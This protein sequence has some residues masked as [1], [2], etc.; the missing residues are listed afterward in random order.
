MDINRIIAKLQ[1]YAERAA[2]LSPANLTAFAK[3]SKPITRKPTPVIIADM[4]WCAVRH[5]LGFR[6]YAMW[7]FASLN[8]RERKTWMTHPRS[9]LINEQY[10]DPQDRL[11]FS[12]KLAFYG[13][14]DE[15]LG[16]SWIN[17]KTATDDDFASFVQAHPTVVVKPIDGH[18]GAGVEKRDITSTGSPSALRNEL[19]AANQCLIEECIVQ[20]PAIAQ[21]HPDSVNTVRIIGF[22]RGAGDFRILAAV[23]RIGNGAAV[24][25]FASGGMYTM[26]G[27][28]GV[29]LYPAVNKN[30]EVF[31][32]HPV[33]GKTIAGFKVP[34]FTETIDMLTKAA[35]RIPTVPYVGWDVAITETGPI[36]IEGNHN[37]SVFQAKPSVSGSKIGLLPHYQQQITGL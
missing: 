37:S 35:D 3:Q 12:D 14:F 33:S 30:G 7:E 22:R 29:A 10:N 25:N 17:A 27:T 36:I 15:F 24:D 32:T 13:R 20:H 16:R 11:I 19:I 6:D 18:G 23:L 4:L 21:L 31:K 8:A 9:H 2:R 1:F 28:D 34:F 26:L 5:E